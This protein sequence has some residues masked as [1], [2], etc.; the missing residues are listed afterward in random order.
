MTIVDNAVYVGGHRIRDPDSLEDTFELMRDERGMAWIGLYRP[1][2]EEV[3]AVAEEFGLHPL[4]V[5]DALSGHQRAKLEHYDDGLFVVLRP[6][7][8]VDAAE[9]VVFGELHVFVGPDFVVTIRHAD[10]PDLARV[11][12]RLEEDPDLLARG[13]EAVLYAILD[14]VVDEYAPVV[15]G[16]QGDVDEIEDQLFGEDTEAGLSE[17]IYRLSREVIHFQRAVQPLTALLQSLLEEAT[18]SEAEP[19]PERVELHRSLRDVL[20]HTIRVTEGVDSLRAILDKALTVHSTLVSRRQTEAGLA[21]NDVVRKISS[22]AAILFAP[23]LVAGIYGM[24]FND[25]PELHWRLGYP[26]ALGLM[27]LFGLGLY[28]AFK[29]KK[30][31]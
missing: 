5:E 18:A 21:Q 20:D 28:A 26:W 15:F 19:V 29:R 16:V 2:R 27:V 1:T 12:R 25:M 23:T 22:W 8:Y 4:A 14:Q 6:A 7:R 17:R 10:S 11:R 24:N 3:E 13:P 31:L 30:W 9:T